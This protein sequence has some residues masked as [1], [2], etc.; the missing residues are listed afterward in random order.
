MVA[1]CALTSLAW[2]MVALD[3]HDARSVVV[4]LATV[5]LTA[6][7]LAL[8]WRRWCGVAASCLLVGACAV[9]ALRSAWFDCSWSETLSVLGTQGG[10]PRRLACVE[11]LV[12][13]EPRADES[14]YRDQ[15]ELCDSNDEDTLARFVPDS[16]SV[17]FN[18]DVD[19]MSDGRGRELP[20]A[21][22]VRVVVDGLS[23]GCIPGDRVRITGWL[24]ACSLPRNPGGFDSLRWGR[25]RGI[26]GTL[27][28]SE[29]A[30]VTRI[31]ARWSL[32]AP[33]TATLAR[34]RSFVDATMRDALKEP[35]DAA[36]RESPQRLDV[37]ALI[38][39]STTGAAWP[40]LRSVSKV[41]AA[42]GVQHL[43]AISGFNFGILAGCAL[44]LVRRCS[45]APRIG[46]VVLV[47]L[48]LL[49]VASIESEVSSVRAALMGGSTALALA[50]NRALSFGSVLGGA[51]IAIV[52]CDPLAASEP[53]FQLS[54]AA[55]LG[56]HSLAP[57]LARGM[58]HVVG[59][60]GVCATLVRLALVPIAA[61][62]AAF[63]ATAPIVAFHFG[64]CPLWCVPCTLALSPSFA[65]MVI[66]SNAMLVLQPIA[67]DLASGARLI[68][69]LN[70][71][72]I[73]SVVRWCAT[74][75]GAL[76]GDAT[77]RAV[78]DPH[79]WTIRVDMID[80]G[81]GSC[82]LV[83]SGASAVIFD[84]G[85]L[86]A[87]AVGS[88]TIVPA[89][90]ALGLSSIDA[91][92]ISHPNLDHYGALPEIVRAFGVPR[93][94]VTPHF[95]VWSQRSRSAAACALDA[96][97]E[98]GAT[99]ETTSRGDAH[100]F[101]DSTWS[102]IH[103]DG[104]AQY[105]DSNDGSLII[106]VDCGQ[107]SLLFAGDAAR[108]ACATVLDSP[109]Q[110]QLR[111]ITLFELPHHGSFQPA[112]AA[113]AQRVAS[114]IVVQST[115][116][117]RFLKDPWS[118]LLAHSTRLV[119]ARDCA[120]AVVVKSDGSIALGSWDG[121]TYRWTTSA[122]HIAVPS[123]LTI[124]DDENRSTKNDGV[125]DRA[126][127]ALLDLDLERSRV[128]RDVDL[129]CWILGRDRIT[130]ELGACLANDNATITPRA[131]RWWQLCRR[132]EGGEPLGDF[133]D[134]PQ[135][136]PDL[137]RGCG[138]WWVLLCRGRLWILRAW[139][140]GCRR[141]ERCG[142]E[143]AQWENSMRARAHRENLLGHQRKWWSPSDQRHSFEHKRD[144]VTTAKCVQGG[145]VDHCSVS[146]PH[147]HRAR[148]SGGSD[149]RE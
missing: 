83:R 58:S 119:T 127:A 63:S 89:L 93:V 19:V 112:A 90:R 84:C 132:I 146:D 35:R 16:P 133:V 8:V 56:L 129:R 22:T 53:G 30:L 24:T 4:V 82:Y 17:R 122:I 26:A 57:P 43:V 76:P 65:L 18:L 3:S 137:E 86:G 80:V 55:I 61:S 139:Q 113:L 70:A 110:H 31:G 97:R 143:C 130:R 108:E 33:L 104:M 47:A 111:G 131:H 12:V 128:N 103:P 148:W 20:V 73:L 118:T 117:R 92:L 135:R 123:P 126:A 95:L 25:S 94:L 107:F 23:A 60:Y 81:N 149:K 62:I 29:S 145:S 147:A 140:R 42:C 44:W 78:T 74:L 36:V 136:P 102:V 49:F 15:L 6:H 14:C 2:P 66:S 59:G 98:A 121:H 69:T 41:F 46:G 27:A 50:F 106:R 7:G 124:C 11:G 39:A 72:V 109:E 68:A 91:V 34:W 79:T 5:A 114:E 144:V 32:T 142:R 45:L 40:G 138:E 54:F 9:G 105:A 120:C 10:A 48:A 28:V 88:R 99:I 71:R 52:L 141:W 1:G 96:V 101:G 85:S 116:P 38:A 77:V 125:A 75:P 134:E 37:S 13:S 100:F 67:P 64:T 115:G 21:A 87:A 51:A